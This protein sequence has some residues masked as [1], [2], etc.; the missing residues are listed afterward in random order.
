ME[1][2]SG[3]G[4]GAS[5]GLPESSAASR[6][7]HCA[8]KWEKDSVH[9]SKREK[10]RGRGARG[11]GRAWAGSSSIL[12]P[13]SSSGWS[14][15]QHTSS[16]QTRAPVQIKAAA[17]K[18]L[19]PFIPPTSASISFSP[20]HPPPCLAYC[21]PPPPEP[22][23]VTCFPPT[24]SNAEIQTQLSEEE[25]EEEALVILLGVRVGGGGGTGLD[26]CRAAAG[27]QNPVVLQASCPP[28]GAEGRGGDRWCSRERQREEGWIWGIEGW[29]GGRESD[30][31]MGGIM[32]LWTMAE[33][34][35]STCPSAAG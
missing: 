5:P 25:D 12:H 33:M 11:G 35:P 20:D 21:P 28:K 24:D 30:F 34:L 15:S 9:L 7:P 22:L 3:P 23:P 8:A 31:Q 18:L 1:G 17:H 19:L 6:G 26:G 16:P 4:R 32:R 14:C 27:E 29:A 10:E 2:R 13:S